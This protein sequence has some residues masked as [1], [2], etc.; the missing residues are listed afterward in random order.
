MD[1]LRTIFILGLLLSIDVL[2]DGVTEI[3]Q[4][5]A[6]GRL[7]RVTANGVYKAEYCYDNAGNRKA[8]VANGG[9][10]CIA[11]NTPAPPTGLRYGTHFGN[12]YTVNWVPSAGA[13]Y[14]RLTFGNWSN[15]TVQGGNASQFSTGANTL[16]DRP[17]Y[18]R[19]CNATACSEKA[20][21]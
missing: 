21:F 17:N 1:A 10:D 6:L 13:T 4:Y 2:A 3:Y 18:I 14:Y 5:D 20:Y 16:A 15:Y 9:G 11:A 7:H 19:A 12:G 8:V